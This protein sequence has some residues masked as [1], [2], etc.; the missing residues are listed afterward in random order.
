MIGPVREK[1]LSNNRIAIDQ[2]ADCTAISLKRVALTELA[3][4]WW[5]FACLA[6]GTG[7]A[8]V[9]LL[10]VGIAKGA[11]G[12]LMCFFGFVVVSMFSSFRPA[13]K[14][15]RQSRGA[16]FEIS[17]DRF[18]V[19]APGFVFF[20]R[21]CW[22]REYVRAVAA[23]KGLQIADT[24]GAITTVCPYHSL[25]QLD[26]LAVL[27]R[28]LLNVP[29]DL[30]CRAGGLSV[31]Y[32]GTFWDEPVPGVLNVEPGRMSLRHPLDPQPHLYFRSAATSRSPLHFSVP[33]SESDVNCRVLEHGTICLRIAPRDARCRFD[34]GQ[35]QIRVGLLSLL[36][37]DS[38]IS[39]DPGTTPKSHFLR[40][41]DTDFYVTI[42]C[43]D[44]EALPRALARFWGSQEG[45]VA[46]A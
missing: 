40:D 39:L 19:W 2:R 41:E 45:R 38:R 23:W 7:L 31:R 25:E 29:E 6:L 14:L 28:Q 11:G 3:P 20:Q 17:R 13:T 26:S 44:S 10:I 9:L 1:P 46:D 27:L 16:I 30:P 43:Q 34:G 42:W 37:S 18:S 8:V 35:P 36:L 22:R 4:D 5:L 15:Y 33:L 24:S 21:L 32:T 12:G